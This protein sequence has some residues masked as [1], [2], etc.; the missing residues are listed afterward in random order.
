MYS[1]CFVH[2]VTFVLI[3]NV[4]YHNVGDHT[5]IYVCHNALVTTTQCNYALCS[6]CKLDK[7]CPMGSTS[8]EKQQSRRKI[9]G[10]ENKRKNRY[11]ACNERTAD[12]TEE[13]KHS[14]KD[15]VC[16]FD[17]SYFSK[18]RID[19][20]KRY[21]T[22]YPFSCNECDVHFVDKG[23]KK[24]KKIYESSNQAHQSTLI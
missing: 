4:K 12:C 9:L 15:L 19:S 18:D 20:L 17:G 16:L 5:P 22:K 13:C 10:D 21:G 23:S 7:D 8:N 11:I 24:R 6:N 14:P 1:H 2:F 3:G